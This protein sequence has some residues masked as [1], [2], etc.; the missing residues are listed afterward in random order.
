MNHS[1]LLG[2]DRAPATAPGH[3]TAS[4]GPSDTSDSGSDL[5]GLA[6]FDDGDAMLPVDIAIAADRPHPDGAIDALDGDSDSDS[7]GTGE[8]R[9]AGGDGHTVDGA[10][11]SPDRIVSDPD[12]STF[13]SDGLLNEDGLDTAERLLAA[14]AEEDGDEPELEDDGSPP[15]P[16]TDAATRPHQRRK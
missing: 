7:A 16:E 9:G 4:L 6:D 1:S 13:D 8:R 11:I 5:A 3:D 15:A 14:A 2:I 10:D 12:A